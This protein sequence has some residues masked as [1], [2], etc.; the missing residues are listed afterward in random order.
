MKILFLKKPSLVALL[1]TIIS[2]S[3][4]QSCS[5]SNYRYLKSYE[6]GEIPNPLLLKPGT[7][8]LLLREDIYR[9]TTTK[10][11]STSDSTKKTETVD[12]DYHTMG[13]HICKGVFLDVNENISVNIA[14][15]F[16]LSDSGDYQIIR[17][18]PTLFGK[19]LYIIKKEGNEIK[20]ISEA[21]FGDSVDKI[22]LE[23]GKT[24]IKESGLLSPTITIT[25]TADK[26]SYEKSFLNWFPE[27]ITKKDDYT[28]NIK[29]GLNNDKISQKDPNLIEYNRY[30]DIKREP[31]II[32]FDYSFLSRP[33]LLIKLVDG[34]LFEDSKYNLV[35]L[36]V[37][38]DR[39]E[40]WQNK[41]QE[42]TY[43]LKKLN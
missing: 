43:T 14:E 28:Y 9:E 1:L 15:L 10:E 37:E 3:F 22:T 17:E 24:K 19:Q 2:V 36:K 5:F 4:L 40:V 41:K 35:R 18:T 8:L 6:S 26:L 25:A 20:R 27:T 38:S 39:I 42:R 33:L 12:V 7:E 29:T 32:E 31:K 11:I 21:L 23:E 34:Y 13:F 16:N 30:L